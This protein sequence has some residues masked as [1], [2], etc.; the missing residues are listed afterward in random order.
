MF[1][2][3]YARVQEYKLELIPGIVVDNGAA[4][5]SYKMHQGQRLDERVVTADRER[6]K[7]SCDCKWWETMRLLC[8]HSLTVMHFLGTFGCVPFQDL[9]KEYIKDR[10]T[11]EARDAYDDLIIQ[12]PLTRVEEDDEWYVR[13]S[14]EFGS[15]VRKA[16]RCDRL[17][18]IVDMKAMELANILKETLRLVDDEVVQGGPPNLATAQRTRGKGIAIKKPIVLRPSKNTTRFKSASELSRMKQRKKYKD[19]QAKEAMAEHE[20][21]QRDLAD[22]LAAAFG[23]RQGA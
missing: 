14:A 7:V 6:G 10:W 19:I 4:Y 2:E 20:A 8:R 11:R 1:Q 3:Q 16:V 17:R 5:T 18:P 15:M 9:P 12:R 23:G 13:S 21:L 22:Q